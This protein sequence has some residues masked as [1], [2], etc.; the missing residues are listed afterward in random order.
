LRWY[1]DVLSGWDTDRRDIDQGHPGQLA[2]LA[3]HPVIDPR[4]GLHAGEPVR[5]GRAGQ[6]VPA[7]FFR[8]LRPAKPPRA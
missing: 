3:D 5:R 4:G 6:R 1:V 8:T 7:A 2:A